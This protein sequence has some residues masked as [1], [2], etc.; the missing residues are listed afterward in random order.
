MAGPAENF[1]MRLFSARSASVITDLA[2]VLWRKRTRKWAF[3]LAAPRASC[4]INNPTTKLTLRLFCLILSAAAEKRPEGSL[5]R[6]K[7]S[8]TPPQDI[9]LCCC[10]FIIQ[11]HKILH[12]PKTQNRESLAHPAGCFA[13]GSMRE[14]DTHLALDRELGALFIKPALRKSVRHN[15]I[16]NADS[17][18]GVNKIVFTTARKNMSLFKWTE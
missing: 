18:I 8:L 9:S 3:E 1:W 2:N 13:W 10:V 14:R 4:R 11:A 17:P 16:L 5:Y 12:T 7:V 6:Q 15:Y